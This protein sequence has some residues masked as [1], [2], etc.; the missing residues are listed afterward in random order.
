MEQFEVGKIYTT[1]SAC[2]H[3]CIISIKVLRR[4]AKTITTGTPGMGFKPNTS[5]EKTF[6]V[7][8]GYQGH[9]AIMPWGRGSMMP[10]L[11]AE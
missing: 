6:R 9:E 5:Q 1:R 8:T 7:F 2:D 3:N 4:T 10:V 11:S